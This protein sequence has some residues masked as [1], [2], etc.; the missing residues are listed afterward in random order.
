[1]A[2]VCWTC[3]HQSLYNISLLFSTPH[4][5]GSGPVFPTGEPGFPGLLLMSNPL[6]AHF[7]RAADIGLGGGDHVQDFTRQIDAKPQ[8]PVWGLGSPPLPTHPDSFGRGDCFLRSVKVLWLRGAALEPQ[9][10]GWKTRVSWSDSLPQLHVFYKRL[11]SPCG[12]CP[13]LT[14]TA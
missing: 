2:R 10:D 5:P 12:V 8:W 1:M 9:G 4:V 11:R 7:W 14:H 6:S 3:P 13:L